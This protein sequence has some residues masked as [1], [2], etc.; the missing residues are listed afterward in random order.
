M[1]Y[2]LGAI[3]IGTKI[4]HLGVSPIDAKLLA[5]V[6]VDAE[7]EVTWQLARRQL[8]WR[9]AWRHDHSANTIGVEL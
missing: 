6:G 7:L 2:P 4:K 9:Q 3:V 8:Y 1:D 5:H